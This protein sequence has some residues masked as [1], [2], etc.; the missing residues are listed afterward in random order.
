MNGDGGGAE[1][2]FQRV[3]ADGSNQR[4]I[5]QIGSGGT[6]INEGA[7]MLNAALPNQWK[8]QAS[9]TSSGNDNA[10]GTLVQMNTVA[11]TAVG[12][13]FSS[14][15]SGDGSALGVEAVAGTA[16]T[17]TAYG[18]FG[19]ASGNGSG[20]KYGI[21][22]SASG[23]GQL[24]AGY[25]A[26]DVHVQGNLS[27][28]GGG[29]L[30]DHV[31]DPENKTLRHNFVES[32]EHLCAYRGL[33]TL[34]DAGRAIVTLP[35]YFAALT[36]EAAATV[37]LTAAGEEPTAVSYRWND[38]HVAFTVHGQ[39]GAEVSWLVLAARDDPVVHQ[40]A[41]PVEEEKGG[42]HL[43][44]GQM[45]NPEAYGQPVERGVGFVAQAAVAEARAAA[46]EAPKPEGIA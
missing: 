11:G 15:A 12:A 35:D 22:S 23:S 9:T 18:L 2:R 17:G 10:L 26:G 25:F 29:F 38:E 14:N 27:K 5:A 7:F 21:Y 3:E 4:N 20:T 42:D 28:A 32:P 19:F 41:R 40:I 33:V 1:F 36:D 6:F 37:Q 46:V 34:D 44:P 39:A 24:Y 30:I 8:V 45:L 16:G 43:A 31:L 13:L